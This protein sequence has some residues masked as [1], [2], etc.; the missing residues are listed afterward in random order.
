MMGLSRRSLPETTVPGYRPIADYGLIGDCHSAALISKDGSIDWLCLPRFDS[1]SV[2]G[3]LLDAESGGHFSVSPAGAFESQAEYVPDTCILTTT[4]RI[5]GGSAVLTD[6]MPLERGEEPLSWG[7]PHASRRIVRLIEANEGEVPLLAEF[8]PRPDYG[9]ESAALA[10]D[11]QR[12]TAHTRSGTV[13]RLH[14]D[15]PLSV[16]GDRATGRFTLRCGERAALILDLDGARPMHERALPGAMDDLRRTLAFWKPWCEQ[17]RYRGAYES[18]VMRSALTRKL[19]TYAPTGAMVA[20]PTTSLPEQIGGARNWDYRYTWIRDASFA[21]HGLLTAGHIEDAVAFF[22]W[23]CHI[24]L[25]CEPGELQIMYGLSG[26]KTLTEYSLEHLEGYCRSRPVRVGN[27]ASTQFQLDVYGELL[28]CFRSYRGIRRFSRGVLQHVWPGFKRQ[29][30]QVIARWREP[31]SGIWEM[32]TEPRHF[33]YSKVMAWTAVDRGIK[34]AEDLGL[35]AD[36]V[37]WSRERAAIRAEVLAKGYDP[38]L[39]SFTQSYGVRV[40]DAATLLLP[41]VGFIDARDPRMISTIE[42]ISRRLL[43]DGLVYRYRGCDDGLPGDEAAFSPCTFWLVD[44]LLAIGRVAEAK[45]LFERMLSKAT[46]LGLFSEE[47]VP[48]S[49]A[50]LGNFPQA[51]TH[52]GLM[53]SAVKLQQAL[54]AQ[55]DTERDNVA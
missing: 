32:R 11:E 48:H 25:R 14:S 13:L 29:V 4:F 36:L 9:R 49:N 51:L 19:L 33:V 31:D 46:P 21:A 12:V 52:I 23:V 22:D 5:V 16:S 54:L 42:A 39:Q 45:E 37:A 1:P 34:A 35:E 3:R 26:E 50:H 27:A 55:G 18:L 43:V 53:N 38:A 47:M 41:I 7:K 28:E 44:N 24:A 10:A 2:F 20:A 8:R 6:F 17:C 30:D 15:I 40:V